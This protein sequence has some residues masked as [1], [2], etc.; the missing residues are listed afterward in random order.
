MKPTANVKD[1]LVLLKHHSKKKKKKR[2]R[3]YTRDFQ[4]KKCEK[5]I[6]LSKFIWTLK[7]HGITPIVKWS[8]VSSK[9]SANYSKICVIE[10]FHIIWPLNDNNFLKKKSEFVNKCQHQNKLLLLSSN[11]KRNLK[12][13]HIANCMINYLFKIFNYN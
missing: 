3:N 1:I 11:V 7:S 13:L 5:C 12:I 2:F 8:I 10:N 6:E 9:T 4:H